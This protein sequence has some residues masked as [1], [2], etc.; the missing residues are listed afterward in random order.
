MYHEKAEK[1]LQEFKQTKAMNKGFLAWHTPYVYD[2]KACRTQNNPQHV[3][4]TIFPLGEGIQF[5]QNKKNNIVDLNF[6]GLA[7]TMVSNFK[8]CFVVILNI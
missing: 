3:A 1:V 2:T 7:V 8:I 4:K 6:P 5:Q